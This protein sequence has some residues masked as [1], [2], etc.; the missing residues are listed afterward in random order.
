LQE[1]TQ[2]KNLSN[3]D[4]SD[5]SLQENQI[6]LDADE[7]DYIDIIKYQKQSKEN[8]PVKPEKL[9]IQTKKIQRKKK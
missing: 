7:L 8:S 4:Y 2:E 5:S 3:D 6:N 1:V 9:E